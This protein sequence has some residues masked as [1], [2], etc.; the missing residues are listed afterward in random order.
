MSRSYKKVA[1]GGF[2]TARSD[3]EYKIEEHRRY[4]AVVRDLIMNGE[5][6]IFPDYEGEYGNPWGAPKDGKVVWW[7][8]IHRF[9][10]Q[11]TVLEKRRKGLHDGIMRW[12]FWWRPAT[13]ADWKILIGK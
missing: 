10:A 1:G 4:R 3:K 11:H 6:E 9:L 5:D 13:R 8:S 2:T 7:W 12:H